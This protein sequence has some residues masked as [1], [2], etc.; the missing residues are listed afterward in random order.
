MAITDWPEAERPREKLLARG[1]PALSD[2]ELLAIFLRVGLRGGTAVDLGR[3]LLLQSGGLRQLLELPPERMKALRGLGGSRSAMLLAALEVGRRF[4][5][6]EIQRGPLLQDPDATGR[7]LMA[8]LRGEPSEVFLVL[9][10][11]NKHRVRAME[12]MFRG[13]V[14]TTPVYPREVVRRAIEH[15]ASSVIVAHNHPSGVAEPSQADREVTE[16]LCR[17]LKLVDV[18]V[19]DHLV[20]GDG[21]WES[22][23]RRGWM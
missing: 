4:L 17:A 8:E 10:L 2:A 13:T 16:L 7:L 14:D 1:A 3:S 19:L 9:F 20:I 5:A 11:D 22:F 23:V 6:A 12:K 15:N 18:Q 21:G